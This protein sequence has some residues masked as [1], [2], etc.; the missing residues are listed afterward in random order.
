MPQDL[1]SSQDIN[2]FMFLS[3][4]YA[5]WFTCSINRWV[6]TILYNISRTTQRTNTGQVPA[7]SQEPA[8][9]TDTNIVETSTCLKTTQQEMT[10]FI[11]RYWSNRTGS[12]SA[13]PLSARNS[14]RYENILRTREVL[15]HRIDAK[16][17]PKA[18]SEKA[19]TTVSENTYTFLKIDV[20][21]TAISSLLAPTGNNEQASFLVHQ[22][23]HTSATVLRYRRMFMQFSLRVSA[24]EYTC[25]PMIANLL[26]TSYVP[27]SY[28]WNICNSTC[29]DSGWSTINW[30]IKHMHAYVMTTLPDIRL[31]PTVDKVFDSI[32]CSPQA[33]MEEVRDNFIPPFG[34]QIAVP[35]W[36][37]GLLPSIN[38]GFECLQYAGNVVDKRA[39]IQHF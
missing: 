33:S 21:Q 8:D 26:Y 20:F 28:N 18:P 39:A 24:S 22:V 15:G 25:R 10:N 2:I 27:F 11:V 3:I 31:L 14:Y 29:K 9:F 37:C 5:G 34:F 7:C 16:I 23:S 19:Q 38:T 36:C 32:Q 1:P 13:P 12:C 35:L 17:F 4:K 6:Q 30:H